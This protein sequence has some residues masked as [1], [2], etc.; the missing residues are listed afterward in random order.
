MEFK[1]TFNSICS[2]TYQRKKTPAPRGRP[3]N[4]VRLLG[5]PSA[6][7]ADPDYTP[8]VKRGRG[9][10]RK[11]FPQPENERCVSSHI[12]LC[13]NMYLINIK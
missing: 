7:S 10:P 12:Y 13:R 3:R 9:R 1:S 8:P 2:I 11:Y 6:I 4:D 5:A